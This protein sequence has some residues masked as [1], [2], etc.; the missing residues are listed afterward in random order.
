VDEDEVPLKSEYT[1]DRYNKAVTFGPN[2]EK[3]IKITKMNKFYDPI[4]KNKRTKLPVLK[5][6][7]NLN[8]WSILKDAVGKDL[9]KFCVPGI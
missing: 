9:S 6:H 8:V 4:Y 1:G 3:T 2:S 5:K 7:M